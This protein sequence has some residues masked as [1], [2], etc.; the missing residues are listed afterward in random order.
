MGEEEVR[1]ASC[2][3]AWIE[4]SLRKGRSPSTAVASCVEAW[5]EITPSFRFQ[6]D[7]CVASCVEAWIEIVFGE[8][9]SPG[10]RSL[11]A[12]KRGLK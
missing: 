8:N 4:I 10:G 6:S 7:F 3:E 11:P 2:V 12:W 5:I 1:V 9:V